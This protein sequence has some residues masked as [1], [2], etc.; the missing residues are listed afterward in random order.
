[1]QFWFIIADNDLSEVIV[2]L[3]KTSTLSADTMLLL[4]WFL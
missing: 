3:D 1:M 4:V 2:L